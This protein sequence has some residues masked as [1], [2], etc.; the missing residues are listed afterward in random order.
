MARMNPRINANQRARRCP[1]SIAQ[2]GNKRMNAPRVTDSPI[3][4]PVGLSAMNSGGRPHPSVWPLKTAHDP[5]LG[6]H[7]RCSPEV[8]SCACK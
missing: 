3:P 7:I 1:Y 8:S 4:T 5:T 6:L 2:L